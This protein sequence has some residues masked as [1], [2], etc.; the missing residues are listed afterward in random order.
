VLLYSEGESNET[1]RVLAKVTFERGSAGLGPFTIRMTVFEDKHE[2]S[3]RFPELEGGAFGVRE[4]RLVI[5]GI[6]RVK[7]QTV[8]IVNVGCPRSRKLEVQA[9]ARFFPSTLP[10]APASGTGN[11]PCSP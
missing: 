3:L 8:P 7:D 4:F 9:E 10:A 6:V 1:A 2:A 11:A 5:G